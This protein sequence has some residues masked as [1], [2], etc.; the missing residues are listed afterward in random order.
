MVVRAF[1]CAAADH[2]P[3]IGLVHRLLGRRAPDV[4]QIT[5]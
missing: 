1:S 3:R 2:A 5:L 4:D